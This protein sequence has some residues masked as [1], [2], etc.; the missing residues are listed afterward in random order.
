MRRATKVTGSN[1]RALTLDADTAADCADYLAF[2]L[3]TIALD[4]ADCKAKRLSAPAIA[5]LEEYQ[6]GIAGMLARFRT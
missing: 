1:G 4:I 3:E 2:A 5:Q 6:S